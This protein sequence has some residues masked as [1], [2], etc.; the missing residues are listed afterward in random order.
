VPGT[1]TLAIEIGEAVLEARARHTDAVDSVLA[2]TS[3]RR[4][5]SGK[6]ADVQRALVGGFARGVL[7]LDGT[8]EDSGR[9]LTIDFQNENLIATTGEGDVLAIVPDLICIVDQETAEPITTEILRYGLRVVVLGIPAPVELKTP[10]ALAVIGPK[11]FGYPNV[12][13]V[14]L[15]GVYGE[16]SRFRN[17]SK[18]SQ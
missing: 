3:G 17:A 2:I 15:A 7:K 11:A 6:I 12:E 16:G 9:T 8:G 14:P 1:I 10:E 5:F 4:L 18:E 13:F